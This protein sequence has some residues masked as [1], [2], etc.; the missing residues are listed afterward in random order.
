[1]L[2]FQW[3][4][5]CGDFNVFLQISNADIVFVFFVSLGGVKIE[6]QRQI[7]LLTIVKDEFFTETFPSVGN[8]YAFEII[9]LT[10]F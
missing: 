4:E 6:N 8:F 7:K 9:F 2:L 1:M 10:Q 3:R 5:E